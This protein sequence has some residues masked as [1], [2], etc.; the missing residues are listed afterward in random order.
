VSSTKSMIGHTFGAADAIEAIFC[1]VAT[2]DV[3][4]QL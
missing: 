4:D 3:L 2:R 1:P